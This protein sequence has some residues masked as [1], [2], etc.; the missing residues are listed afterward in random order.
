MNNQKGFTLLE[1]LVA[2]ALASLLLTSIY[3]VFSTSSIAKEQVEK[4]SS[5]LHL[6]RVLSDRLDRELLGLALNNHA[7][8]A[9]LTGG[10]NDRA[11]PYLELLTSSSG[12]PQPGMRWVNYRL[13]PDQDERVTL[14]RSEKSLNAQ[15]EAA[16]ERLAQGI[17]RL[18]FSFF[19]GTNW[20]NS[21]DGLADGRPILVQLEI[22][23]SDMPDR[24]PLQCV[25]TLPQPGGA[26]AGH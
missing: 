4:K 21:W 1:V 14:W 6:V 20:R 17:D 13:G 24:P 23:L 2:I 9:I 19:D 18:A 22:E 5:A 25:F 16:E 26:D 3:G 12:G 7:G 10:T 15:T 11:E 8:K